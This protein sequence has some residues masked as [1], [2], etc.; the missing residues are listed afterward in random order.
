MYHR[1]IPRDLFNE[2]KLLKCLGQL[3][4]IV[5]DGLDNNRT[6]CPGGLTADNSGDAF[7]ISQREH[8]GGLVAAGVTFFANGFPLTLFSQYNSKSPYPLWCETPGEDIA[9]FNDDGNLTQ[10]FCEH[11]E[12]YL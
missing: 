11:V 5:H 8:D 12:T 4:L 9:V 10:E 6:K 1:V 2:S 7:D 3:S